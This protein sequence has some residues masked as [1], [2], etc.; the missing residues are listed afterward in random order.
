VLER[1]AQGVGRSAVLWRGTG[2]SD[3]DMLLL[4]GAERAL[5]GALTGAGFE[6]T[7]G[8][9][10]RLV[11][12]SQDA[13]QR[14]VD[15]ISWRSWP[16]HYP[17]LS[18]FL[19]R[20]STAETALPAAS[21]EDRLLILAA[22]AAAGR[23]LAHIAGKAR[24]LLA[25]PGVLGR[26]QALARAERAPSLAR[27]IV[28]PNLATT[29]HGGRIPY[30]EL[31]LMGVR[32]RRA[33]AALAVRATGRIRAS[34][35]PRP[36]LIALSGMDGSGK[37]TLADQ[38]LAQ[39]R[40]HGVPAE[41]SWVRLAGGDA[42]TLGRIAAPVK[43]I[44]RHRHAISDPVAS[45]DTG[46]KTRDPRAAEG[47]WT[48]VSW[49]WILVVAASAARSHRRAAARRRAGVAVVCDRWLIDALVDLQVRYGR[50]RV[51]A[52]LLRTLVPS[53]EAAILLEVDVATSK[54]RKPEDQPERVL[55]SM[56]RLYEEVA[57][58]LMP[59]RVDAR[60]EQRLVG[61]DVM[62]IVDSLIV[63]S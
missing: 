10:G 49:V 62:R 1:L 7:P 9:P 60:R 2:G 12:S 51:A 44:L 18:G 23:P 40:A 48:P 42:V 21:P 54:R 15:V 39:L 58:G 35:R 59:I 11:W 41:R 38:V 25:Q 36:M 30:R 47:R 13:A 28:R 6:P 5:A 14:E 26:L 22:E 24:P 46:A 20:C 55:K 52:A 16:R 53:P 34:R 57:D 8:G 4:P 31:V 33:R 45:G 37:S 27:L 63:R 29:R 61:E 43:R 3:V 17:R 56:E 50:H 19:E 32:D